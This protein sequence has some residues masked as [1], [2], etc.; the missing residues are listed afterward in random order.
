[1]LGPISM[2]ADVANVA[3]APP[4]ERGRAVGSMIGGTAGTAIGSAIGSVLLPG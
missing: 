2:L 1:M 4:E 3:T